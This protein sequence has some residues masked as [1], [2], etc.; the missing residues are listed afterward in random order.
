M[1]DAAEARVRERLGD[2]VYGLEDDTLASATGRLLQER[3][4]TVAV[5]ESCTGGLLGKMWTD[6]PGSSG[7]FLGGV[8]AY[9]DAIKQSLL[10]VPAEM[11]LHEG[12]VSAA[13]AGKMAE[14][15]RTLL[16][17][18]FG[19]SI[20]G[21]AGPGG[22]SAAKPVGQVFLGLAGPAG[23]QA[24]E[25]RYGP[26]QPRTVIREWAARACLNLLRLELLRMRTG[27]QGS[28]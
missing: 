16:D 27:A 24:H 19:L 28:A 25:V 17:S 23:A 7:Y 15:V 26:A 8:I 2:S 14:G 10:R 11:L 9:A 3:G 5:A 1:L 6:T 13:V 20:T 18:T 12:A 21:V 4:A 22:G